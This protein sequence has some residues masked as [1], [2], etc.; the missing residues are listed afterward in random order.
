MKD[1]KK[2]QQKLLDDHKNLILSE[3]RKYATNLPVEA[4]QIEAFR[5]AKEAAKTFDPKLE[6]KFSTHLVNS[7][8]KLS[9][10]S[11]QYGNTIR[12]PEN[13]QYILN[14]INKVTKQHEAEE[15]REPTLEEISEK[16]GINLAT[17]NNILQNKKQIVN[18]ANMV[19]MPTL[20]D[21]ED[22]E[23]IHFVYHD[24]VPTDKI[25]MEHKTG[26]GGKP[27]LSSEEL[28]KKLNMSISNVNSRIRLISKKIEQGLKN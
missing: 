10:L 15:G 19:N 9:R 20:I 14:K 16:S 26:F 6:F 25:I 2:E 27:L 24:L 12:L 4:L 22:D 5:I 3:A 17:V 21:G 1:L 8:Q 18:V 7:L 11:T 23:W 28:A 13:Q